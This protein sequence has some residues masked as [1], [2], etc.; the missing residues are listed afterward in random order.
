MA[1]FA[2]VARQLL[3]QAKE[4]GERGD[5]GTQQAGREHDSGLFGPAD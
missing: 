1:E 4:Y 2:G 3:K 5:H